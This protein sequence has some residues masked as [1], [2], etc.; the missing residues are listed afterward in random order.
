MTNLA[1]H[2]EHPARKTHERG[3]IVH[4]LKC[5]PKFFGP[6]I[7]GRKRHDLRRAG[8]RDFRIGDRMVLREFCPQ[9][10]EYTGR[11]QTVE[12]S[13]IT[14]AKEPCA[15]SDQ[16]LHGDFCILSIMLVPD[17]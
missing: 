11:S 15:L 9:S 14:S 5:W 17:A 6:I 16:A 12:I 1:A 3:P 13:Y 2:R 8:D 10:E 7:E 4:E